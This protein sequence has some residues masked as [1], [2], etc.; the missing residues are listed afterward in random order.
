MGRRRDIKRPGG[1]SRE[2]NHLLYSVQ[3]R[4]LPRGVIAGELSSLGKY[5]LLAFLVV[6]LLGNVHGPGDC[7]IETMAFEIGFVYDPQPELI[8]QVKKFWVTWVMAAAQGIDVVLL[9]QEQVS[10]D[11]IHRHSTAKPGVVIVTIDAVEL[12][13]GPVDANQASNE[14]DPAEP[15]VLVNGV[16]CR[17]RCRERHL[18]GLEIGCFGSPLVW[19]ANQDTELDLSIAL[20]SRFRTRHRFSA[21]LARFPDRDHQGSRRSCLDIDGDFEVAVCVVVVE[22]GPEKPVLNSV[23]RWERN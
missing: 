9:H 16:G 22:I 4:R 6:H 15:N 12:E 14:L 7:I 19:C 17:C 1:S 23:L 2:I 5:Q 13:G 20:D 10:P 8:G 21:I 18:D 11:K 3:V